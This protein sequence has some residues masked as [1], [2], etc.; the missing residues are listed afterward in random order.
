MKVMDLDS[1]ITQAAF[2]ELVGVSQP[3][4]HR[5]IRDGVLPKRG[6]LRI[7]LRAY[8][9]ALEADRDALTGAGDDSAE[10]RAARLELTK[11]NTRLRT[12]QAKALEREYEK[13]AREYVNRLVDEVRVVLF[14]KIPVATVGR[15]L[16]VI[17]EQEQRYA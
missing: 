8:I 6:T 2:A 12:T 11:A 16:N 9:A 15:L 7:W 14:T 1:P 4:I 13:T 10:A 17:P 3:T 5:M